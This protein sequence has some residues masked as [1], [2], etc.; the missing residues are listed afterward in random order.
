MFGQIR[1]E[2]YRLLPPNVL[3]LRQERRLLVECLGYLIIPM[4]WVGPELARVERLRRLPFIYGILR[5]A[6][7][8]R[9]LRS[10]PRPAVI[11]ISCAASAR[12]AVQRLAKVQRIDKHRRGRPVLCHP[13]KNIEPV[14]GNAGNDKQVGDGLE[15]E[16]SG[17]EGGTTGGRA[18]PAWAGPPPR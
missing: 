5:L 14:V 6:V 8:W 3:G 18:E 11:I 10:S 16:P 7:N 12:C 1:L 13:V 4:R 15:Q 2:Y 9:F 17:A